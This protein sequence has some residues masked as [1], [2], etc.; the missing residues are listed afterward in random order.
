M[1]TVNP[2]IEPSNPD[3]SNLPKD[4]FE[5]V[6]IKSQT[7]KKLL[8]KNQKST[9]EQ[10][11]KLVLKKSPTHQFKNDELQKCG[12]G[13]EECDQ[14]RDAISKADAFRNNLFF[15][16]ISC[17]LSQIGSVLDSIIKV[18]LVLVVFLLS[19]Q[20]PYINTQANDHLKDFVAEASFNYQKYEITLEQF[21][22]IFKKYKIK[23]AKVE[24]EVPQQIKQ[25]KET[26]QRWMKYKDSTIESIWK[27]ILKKPFD[28]QSNSKEKL[29]DLSTIY[30]KT[31]KQYKPGL[32]TSMSAYRDAVFVA[33]LFLILFIFIQNILG[34]SFKGWAR[35]ISLKHELRKVLK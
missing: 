19:L 9:V 26:S 22:E 20:V 31:I 1:N 4:E 33:L 5:K 16:F 30:K 25:D 18:G 14:V 2:P 23:A 8:N 3:N 7:P 6:K 15:S 34:L 13:L 27:E 11:V 28:P 10:V 35:S 17:I 24:E 29:D 32:P 21:S 12:V